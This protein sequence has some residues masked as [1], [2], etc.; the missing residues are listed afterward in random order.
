MNDGNS[1][2]WPEQPAI[3]PTGANDNLAQAADRLA[4]LEAE[5]ARYKDQALRALADAENVRRRAE[6]ERE[7]AAKYG[8]SQLA[9]DLLPVADN[10]RRAIESVDAQAEQDP[11][12]AALLTGIQATERELVTALERRGIKKIEPMGEK[13]DPNFHQA[14]F[15]V[16][17]DEQPAG[18]VVQVLQPGYV[19]HDR[20]LR[21]AMVGIAKPATNTA[22]ERLDT[23]V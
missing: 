12:V 10:L 2:E 3:D 8:V 20:L 18:T 15:E 13:F 16:P 19:I 1:P 11:A 22:A 14:M 9:R 4:E 21:P 17:T 23:Q 6:R 5:A 7:D